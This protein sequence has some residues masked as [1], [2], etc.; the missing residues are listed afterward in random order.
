MS[1]IIP[2]LPVTAALS[3]PAPASG[4]FVGRKLQIQ[5]LRYNPAQPEVAPTGRPTNWTTRRA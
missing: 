5:V 3:A 1:T 4:Q 2:I